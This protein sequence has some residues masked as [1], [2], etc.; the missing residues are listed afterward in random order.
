MKKNVVSFL[1]FLLFF[2]FSCL[3][4]PLQAQH[5]IDS[6]ENKL[7]AYPTQDTQRIFLLT[8]LSNAYL[9]HAIKIDSAEIYINQALVLAQKL[10]NQRALATA[11]DSKGV[12]ERNNARYQKAIEYHKK[13]QEIALAIND[14]QIFLIINNNL[15][16]AHR[17]MGDHALALPYHLLSLR[18]A[19]SLGDNMNITY[20]LN[21][22]GNLYLQMNE[23][24]KATQHFRRAYKIDQAINNLLGLSINYNNLGLIYRQ[25]QKYDSALYFL[26]ESLKINQKTNNLKGIAICYDDL[27]TVYNLIGNK[28][29]AL[30][31]FKRALRIAHKSKDKIYVAR[32]YM[33]TGELYADDKQY[34]KATYFLEES[35]KMAKVIRARLV[36]KE[37]YFTLAKV[38]EAT[39]D[40][41]KSLEAYKMAT[42]Y[43][44][45]TMLEESKRQIDYLQTKFAVEKREAEKDAQ[46]KLLK[47]DQILQQDKI[48]IQRIV[49]MVLIGALLITA[50]VIIWLIH[51]NGQKQRINKQLQTQQVDLM[52]QKN[53]IQR[54]KDELDRVNLVK[55]RLFS[56]IGH[57]LRS[58]FNTI[59]GFIQVLRAGN[60][61]E[62]EIKTV[63]TTIEQQLNNTLTLLNNLLY[64]SWSQM[65][66]ITPH[67]SEFEINQIFQNNIDLQAENAR[68]KDLTITNQI[69][70]KA[71]VKADSNMID[72]VVRNLIANAIKFTYP[73]GQIV[74]SCNS[75]IDRYVFCIA[76]NG[77]GL[78][79]HQLQSLFGM[80]AHSTI[81]TAHEKGTGLGLNICK[82]FLEKN[83]GS[84]W[85]ESEPNKGSKF[86]F[87]LPRVL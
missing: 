24:E 79:P 5:F 11:Y 30:E 74:V 25:Q 38:Y 44:D 75:E 14:L 37:S 70:Q 9:Q 87:T 20:N 86:Y 60:L 47:K 76:D 26:K 85:V 31:H 36:L 61:N 51:T 64:W 35:I 52:M 19:D 16:V 4:A 34:K 6:L 50:L 78:T 53:E 82:E 68:K 83:N 66:G 65:Q 80:K 15:G 13:A 77:V 54:Q 17:R 22:L 42:I 1:V 57:D 18:I 2:I 32:I 81:G 12:F 48:F 49:G 69:T 62:E 55:D 33:H 7:R 3:Y 63:T 56:I 72:T 45:S 43:K 28:A 8:R 23:F 58:P 73:K 59:K 71:K 27:G 67:P 84:I 29:E 40:Y 10:Q 21:S 46:I 41:N 39:N